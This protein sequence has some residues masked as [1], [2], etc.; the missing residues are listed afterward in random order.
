MK[1]ILSISIALMILCFSCQ[2][3]IDLEVPQN[4]K[5]IVISGR[6]SDT[7]ESFVVISTTADYFDQ[8]QSP[9]VENADVFL[10]EDGNQVAQLAPDS[11]PGLYT[12]SFLGTVGRSYEIEV[13]ISPNNPVFGA[14]TWRSEPEELKRVFRVDSF[15]IRYLDRNTT[16]QVFTEGYYALIHFQ[17]PSGPGDNYR[18]RFWEND[19]LF[20]QNVF[21]FNDDNFDGFYVGDQL[22]PAFNYFGPFQEDQ[23]SAGIEISSI[24]RSYFDYLVLLNQQVFQVGSTFDPPPASVIGNIYN[25]DNPNEKGFGYFAASS[26]EEGGIRYL[27]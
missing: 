3:P 12:S 26:L 27:E 10:Y 6:V 21:I 25:K 14:S 18:M 7:Q 20:T 24:T 2:D 5:T 15:N 22:I 13:V 9:R 4:S 23:D 1:K 8:G 19:S 16:P 17:E 11:V